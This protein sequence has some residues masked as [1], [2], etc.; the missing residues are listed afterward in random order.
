MPLTFPLAETARAAL[1]ALVTA[2]TVGEARDKAGA[3]VS[4]VSEWLRP[5][6][7]ESESLQEQVASGI[8][9]GYV[10]SYEDNQ[11]NP[12][13]S[14]T[15]WRR[16]LARV[17]PQPVM[18]PAPAE[19]AAPPAP[20]PDTVDDLY[21]EK[22]HTSARRGGNRRGGRRPSDPNQLDL[23]TGPDQAGEESRDPGNP[24]VVLVDEEGSGATFGLAPEIQAAPPLETAAAKPRAKKPRKPPGKS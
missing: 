3:P 2:R 4:L 24:N 18:R 11:G 9:Q 16:G 10:Q 23:F 7:A 14:V 13:F 21:F 22:P 17:V 20:P 12:V 6:A 19:P 5:T 15:F 8:S 1:D